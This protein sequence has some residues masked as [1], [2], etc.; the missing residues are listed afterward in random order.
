MR[1]HDELIKEIDKLP[2]RYVGEV[3]DFVGYLQQKTQNEIGNAAAAFKTA[4]ADKERERERE[5]LEWCNAYFGP[6]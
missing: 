1:Q 3:F 2:A 5:A 4:V 6:L